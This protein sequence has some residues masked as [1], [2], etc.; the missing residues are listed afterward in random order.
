MG[1]EPKALETIASHKGSQQGVH[2]DSIHMT[3]YPRGYLAAAWIAFEDIHPD[4]GPLVYYPG[5]HRLP[6]V[7][8]RDV[9]I[10]E[11]D[12]RREGYGTY[13]AKYEP[14]IRELIDEHSSSP[15]IFTRARVTF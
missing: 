6:L 13:H 3:T 10:P 4:C 7:F 1:Q 11:S 5:S 2:S 15:T 8:S 12:F 9:G 14:R